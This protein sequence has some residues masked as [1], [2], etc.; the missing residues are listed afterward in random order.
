MKINRVKEQGLSQLTKKSILEYIKS[1]KLTNTT[2]LPREELLAQDLGVSRIT[3]RSALNE[4]ASEG[5]IFRRQGKG[6]FV[7]REALHMN[8][9]FNPIGDLRRVIADS[10][11]QVRAE[12]LHMEKRKM[13]P[14][15]AQKLQRHTEAEVII[16]ERL[17][18]ANEEPA[19]YC[20]DRLPCDVLR[21]ALT[22]E[23][24]E[25]SMYRY[26]SSKLGRTIVW[27]KVEL[28]TVTNEEEPV[29]KKIFQVD[30]TKSFLNCDIV[31]FDCED[32]PVF[33]ANEYVDTNFI[34]YQLIRQKKF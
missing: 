13:L 5:I 2:K 10:G 29:L 34:R 27:D 23:D 14:L 7:N 12:L 8:V 25:I 17:F 6:T 9:L 11:Y 4:L 21:E 3:V 1:M 22:K 26:L 16:L 24:L 20:I 32:A 30:K 28:S 18:Y 15:E 33:Y 31:N 19:V